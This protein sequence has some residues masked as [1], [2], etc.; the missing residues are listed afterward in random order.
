M[1]NN[2]AQ[3]GYF[4]GSRLSPWLNYS[5]RREGRDRTSASLIIGLS[6]TLT[7]EPKPGCFPEIEPK[8]GCL[9][10]IEVRLQL[11]VGYNRWGLGIKSWG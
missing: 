4:L 5:E 9:P 7:A 1:G 10:E 2:Y 3:L 11:G 8:P 6:V